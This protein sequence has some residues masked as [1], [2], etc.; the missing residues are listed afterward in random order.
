MAAEPLADVPQVVGAVR[1]E[2]L[3]G[4]SYEC[5]PLDFQAHFGDVHETVEFGIG[6]S[7][8][9]LA[10][11][12]RRGMLIVTTPIEPVSGFA[13]NSPPPR[14]CSAR[15]SSRNR[16]HIDRASSGDMSELTKFAKY[17]DPNSP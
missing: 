1:I 13:P 7:A 3:V 6:K 5:L 9:S 10:R 4:E 8:S 14:R 17:A 15:T 2:P 16:Q 11:W 12:P